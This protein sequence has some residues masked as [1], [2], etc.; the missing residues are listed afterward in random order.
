MYGVFESLFFLIKNQ[1]LFLE[2]ASFGVLSFFILKKVLIISRLNIKN[3][4]LP[5][6]LLFEKFTHYKYKVIFTEILRWTFKSIM[7]F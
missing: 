7:V 4:N 6:A 2:V 5:I 1:F 3:N